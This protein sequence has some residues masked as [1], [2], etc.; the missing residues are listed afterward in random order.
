MGKILVSGQARS[1]ANSKGNKRGQ[2]R[3]KRTIKTKEKRPREWKPE[4]H[5]SVCSEYVNQI[6]DRKSFIENRRSQD[7]GFCMH[8]D[9]MN[10]NKKS[11]HK[12]KGRA[13]AGKFPILRENENVF[14]GSAT[15]YTASWPGTAPQSDDESKDSTAH[16]FLFKS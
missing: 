15:V 11:F 1:E 16:D 5:M 4:H 6:F 9:T 12:K 13:P 3:I 14:N 2:G 10:V 7:I 8:F